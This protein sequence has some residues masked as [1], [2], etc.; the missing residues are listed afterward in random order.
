MS[1]A[2]SP[3]GARQTWTPGKSL[4]LPGPILIDI[5]MPSGVKPPAPPAGGDRTP[6][7]TVVTDKN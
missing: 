4:L 2:G 5:P 3:I 1:D 6:S 7:E